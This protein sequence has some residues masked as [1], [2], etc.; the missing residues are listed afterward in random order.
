MIPNV[1]PDWSLLMRL[2]ICWEF[3]V[4]WSLRKIIQGVD[5]IVPFTKHHLIRLLLAVYVFGIVGELVYSRAAWFWVAPPL[6]LVGIYLRADTEN[7]TT[8]INVWIG[9]LRLAAFSLF[10]LWSAF[11]LHSG[12]GWNALSQAA[13]AILQYALSMPGGPPKKRRRLLEAIEEL[14][15]RPGYSTA[16]M[17]A[18]RISFARL[19]TRW[20]NHTA[21]AISAIIRGLAAP[22]NSRSSKRADSH[23][24]GTQMDKNQGRSALESVQLQIWV[25]R[26]RDD[27]YKRIRFGL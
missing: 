6:I 25:W 9:V 14:A 11:S 22:Q 21:F 15:T 26:T 8:L 20:A 13:L 18:S 27:S 17:P 24:L 1:P 2:L 10:M 19:A 4:Y 5:R 16:S 23:R 7:H 3:L 12:Q